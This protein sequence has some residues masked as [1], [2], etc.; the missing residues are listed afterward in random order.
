MTATAVAP[1]RR[2]PQERGRTGGRPLPV[3]PALEPLLPPGG[4]RRGSAV[5]VRG[6]A[7]LLLALLAGP[8]REGAWC[9]VVGV[10]ALGLVAAAETGIA[11]ERLALVPD[12]GPDWPAVAGALLDAM[13]VVVVAPRGRVLDG[14][15]RRLAARARQRGAVLVPYG[16]VRWPGA[17]LR[18]SV[19]AGRW[20]GLAE[21][22][23]LLR[24]RR[25]VV[26]GEGRGSATR[27]RELRLWLPAPGGGVRAD[28]A[29]QLRAV[30]DL[31]PAPP[32]PPLAPATPPAPPPAPAGPSEPSR[33]PGPATPPARPLAPAT[34]PARPL[35]PATPPAPPLAPVGPSEPSRL[36]G[37]AARRAGPL[38]AVPGPVGTDPAPRGAPPR[39]A[40]PG[41]GPGPGSAGPGP[42]GPGRAPTPRP[43]P[44]GSPVPAGRSA[45]V[46]GGGLPVPPPPVG[47]PPARPRI[48]P[49]VL[50]RLRPASTLPR[51]PRRA[52]P[53]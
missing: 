45:A 17:E 28:P 30:P 40:G 44:A 51:P 25:V 9:A 33:L 27:V 24:A 34:P 6:S 22:S 7:S 53:G 37:P 20:E 13:D 18:L 32:A 31:P 10:P 16:A 21:G 8:S 15:V 43:R 23:G 36:P 29:P 42:A 19:A 46:G 41:P 26:R 49:D 1:P 3:L 2:A 48:P 35:A 39:G 38:H 14:E 5:A 50:A 47:A 12:P 11:L 4:L 52:V